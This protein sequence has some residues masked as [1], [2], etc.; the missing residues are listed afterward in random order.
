MKKRS[1]V[2]LLFVVPA[3]A[4]GACGGDSDKDKIT[5]L[6]DDVNKDPATLCDNA[7]KDVLKQ[8]G[9]EE[10]CRKAAKGAPKQTEVK[11]KSVK[12][13]GDKATANVTAK[14]DGK[15]ENNQEVK[16]AKED[17]DWKISE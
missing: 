3:L 4:L 2:A 5:S 15:A 7:T 13:D 11:V 9:G 8:I 16:F 10:G 6:I 12:V 14:V 1:G 17:G